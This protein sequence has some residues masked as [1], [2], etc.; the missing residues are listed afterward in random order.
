MAGRHCL[1]SIRAISS[2]LDGNGVDL[3]GR[4][5]FGR[6]LS[7]NRVGKKFIK[8][9][10]FMPDLYLRIV[11]GVFDITEICVSVLNL[12]FQSFLFYTFQHSNNIERNGNQ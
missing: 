10:G 6:L 5:E 11:L 1:A 8:D 4:V 9:Q 2:E 7:S 12:W 3:G